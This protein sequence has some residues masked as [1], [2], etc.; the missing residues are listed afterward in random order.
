MADDPIA[1]LRFYA[2]NCLYD[3]SNEL[4]EVII[5]IADE[6][7]VQYMK[8][9]IDAD[10]ISV[11]PEDEMK[12]VLG[13]TVKVVAVDSGRYFFVSSL[14]DGSAVYDWRWAEHYHHADPDAIADLLEEFSHRFFACMDSDY[15]GDDTPSCLR[16]EYAKRIREVL[17]NG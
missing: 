2:N 11:R 8:L 10:G 5:R 12:M 15:T 14:A 9:P 6:I 17:I 7:E 13:D 1:M 4:W 3:K 16:E